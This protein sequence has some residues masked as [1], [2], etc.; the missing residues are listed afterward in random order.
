MNPNFMFKYSIELGPIP[1]KAL[2]A[3]EAKLK[4]RP[5]DPSA[6][7]DSRIVFGRDIQPILYEL[8]DQFRA[9]KY[10]L[11]LNNCNHFADA[12]VRRLYAN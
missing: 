5:N 8:Q 4:G 11:L 12:F 7:D 9:Y 10:H 2:R 6:F 3:N 1:A